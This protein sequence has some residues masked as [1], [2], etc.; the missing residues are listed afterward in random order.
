MYKLYKIVEGAYELIGSFG[1]EQECNQEAFELSLEA[2]RIELTQDTWS[3]KIY[4]STEIQQG[5][6]NDSIS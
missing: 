2:F 3:Q 4:D 5:E 1:T 6:I